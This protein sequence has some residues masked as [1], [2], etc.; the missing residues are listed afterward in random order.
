MA[1]VRPALDILLGIAGQTLYLDAL[2]GRPSSITDVKVFAW[3]A[4]DDEELA[5]L[6][7]A[8]AIETNPNTTTDAAAGPA[9]ANTRLVPVTAT[10]GGA[11]G[12]SFLIVDADGRKEWIDVLEVDSGVSFTARHP[13]VNDFATGAQVVSTRMVATLDT[14]WCADEDNIR[15][16]AGANPM[17]RV[18]WTY[19]VGGVTKVT[20]TYFNL[21]R[22]AGVHNVKPSDVDDFVPGWLERLPTDHRVDQGKRLIDEAYKGVQ[23]D[24]HGVNWDDSAIAEAQVVD[25]LV[26]HKVIE[27]TEFWRFLA[28]ADS[29]PTRLEEARKAYRARLSELLLLVANTPERDQATGAA[30]PAAPR[31][32]TVR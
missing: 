19:V 6:T 17:Y 29:D 13:L 28:K 14:E 1:T 20:E 21:V 2:E 11:E 31:R 30:G 22:Y 8:P 12:R 23:L 26:K 32:L 18:K 27:R 5:A 15:T 24:L 4:P 25:E 3:D 9:Q 10:T 16:D 7:G